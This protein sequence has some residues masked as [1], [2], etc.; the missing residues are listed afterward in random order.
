ML[1]E[2]K[3]NLGSKLMRKMVTKLVE[4][5]IFKKTGY[6]VTI[7]LDELDIQYT[8][9]DAKLKT[10]LE[11]KMDKSEFNKIVKDMDIL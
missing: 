6:K 10:N 9:G 3:I 8:D 1:D 2:I 5:M 4:G 11:L 7:N